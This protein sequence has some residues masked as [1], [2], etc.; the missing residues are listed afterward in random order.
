MSSLVGTTS[1]SLVGAKIVLSTGVE[2][3]VDTNNSP[4]LFWAL[5]GGGNNNFGIVTELTFVLRERPVLQRLE[6][7]VW[8]PDRFAEVYCRTQYLESLAADERRRGGF[9]RRGATDMIGSRREVMNR[10]FIFDPTDDRYDPRGELIADIK[11]PPYPLMNIN[12]TTASLTKGYEFANANCPLQYIR[13]EKLP[14]YFAK[15]AILS[16]S[17]TPTG[18]LPEE[19]CE[20]VGDLVQDAPSDYC[21]ITVQFFGGGR[22][23]D[24]PRRYSAFV[25]RDIGSLITFRCYSDKPLTDDE[26]SWVREGADIFGSLGG[27]EAYQNVKDPDLTVDNRWARQYFAENLEKLV[28]IR[29][30]YDPTGLFDYPQGLSRLDSKIFSVIAN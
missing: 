2:V 20:E 6:R 11:L 10:N 12:F 22:L 18:S 30:T 24:Y 13:N 16:E 21:F 26:V 23:N 7:R 8:T 14:Y 3:N 5:K 1:D 9:F 29:E 4:L 28:Q 19:F 17:A 15:T 27:S 25:H